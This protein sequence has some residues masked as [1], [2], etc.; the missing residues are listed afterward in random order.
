MSPGTF[1]RID[2]QQPSDVVQQEQQV[3]A[4]LGQGCIS[5]MGVFGSS[6][7]SGTGREI[8]TGVIVSSV[9]NY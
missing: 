3:P 9:M 6:L 2:A 1:V 8:N 7:D 5:V 4:Y